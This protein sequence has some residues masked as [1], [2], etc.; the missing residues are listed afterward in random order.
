M[1]VESH[2]VSLWS[3]GKNLAIKKLPAV[4]RLKGDQLV[5]KYYVKFDS[6]YKKEIL[7]L[8][9]QGNARKKQSKMLPFYR[10]TD[11]LA[12]WEAN[13]SAVVNFGKP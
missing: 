13:D 5:G 12:R 3:L 7:H 11:M 2:I 4:Q 9:T 10:S 1:I 6:E 8:M